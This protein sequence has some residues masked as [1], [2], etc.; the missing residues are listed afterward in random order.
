MSVCLIVCVGGG[1][2]LVF[3]LRVCTVVSCFFIS[4]VLLW[5]LCGFVLDFAVYFVVSV[6]VIVVV[7]FM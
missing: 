3:V 1:L 6:C 7:V 5:S 4:V 2:C